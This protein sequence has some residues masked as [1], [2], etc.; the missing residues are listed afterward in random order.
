MKTLLNYLMLPSTV[1]SFEDNYLQRMNRIGV[2]FLAA[3]LPFMVLLA[4][5]NDTGPSLA[6]ILTGATLAGPAIAFNCLRSRRS[7]SIV[8]GI[9]SMLLGGLL[10]HFGQG[11]VQ[12]EMHFYFFV[13]LALL[14]VYA[15]PMVIVAAAITAALHHASLWMFLP[16]SVF[17]YDAPF[18]VVGVH[19]AFVVLESVAA[20]F[21]A[22]SFFDNVIGLEKIV[23]SRTAAL[24]SRNQDMRMLLDS[25]QQGFCTID[26]QGTMS[27]ERSAAVGELL[28]D[29]ES[30]SF[31]ELIAQHDEKTA[32]WL[33]FALGEVFDGIMPVEVTLDQMP[34]RCHA[35]D[36]VLDLQYNPVM[37]D[38]GELRA[39]AVVVSDITAEVEREELEA[40]NRELMAMI[41]RISSD[42]AGFL[43][44]FQEASD[45][46]LQLQERSNQD[47]P[48]LK[49]RIHTLKGNA[50]IFGL[51][52][53]AE[54]CHEIED[55]IAEHNELPEE[56]M[57][58]EVFARW[59][60]VQENLNKITSD[61]DTGLSLD[62]EE[63]DAVLQGIL[64]NEPRKVIATRIA[65]WRLEP[66]ARRMT[67]L[68]E[69][70][71]AL[72]RRLGKGDLRVSIEGSNL[73][74]EPKCWRDFWSSF[75][76][77]IRNAVDHGLET[78]QE[79]LASGKPAE[80]HVSFATR[81]DRDRFIVSV[82]DDGGG[83][84][85]Q[86]LSEVASQKGLPANSKA[87]LVEVMFADGVST[88]D[89]ISDTSGRGVGMAAV[90]ASC[91]RLGG[92]IKVDS[93]EGEGTTFHFD[94]PL[95][96]MAPEATETLVLKEIEDIRALL[97]SN[98][99]TDGKFVAV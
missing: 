90:R 9:T 8:N 79:R 4:F 86:K 92:N 40:E 30:N 70:A 88:V 23:E 19:A 46:V 71:Q 64:N 5:L 2:F 38:Q 98:K 44:F 14:A 17:N 45:I 97:V 72:G 77:V 31:A 39:L 41:D 27:E 55:Y 7:I 69:Q 51:P 94:F 66:T 43:E 21:I 54:A 32:E 56:T 22:R 36:R 18:W 93:V 74:T 58:S 47:L 87:E 76:H 63:Y 82:S 28:G 48:L 59:N 13:L 10:V 96:S 15:N 84:D 34:K 52:K 91:E 24:E 50:S 83:I 99:S 29:V 12:I 80:G 37:D 67:R 16:S 42:K 33:E 25:V 95:D 49:R 1:T 53:L 6:F 11:P 78:P 60:R 75:V 3:H 61:S 68:A 73:H 62:D 89:Q 81:I 85:W 20:C 65:S 26:A 57:W 35:N